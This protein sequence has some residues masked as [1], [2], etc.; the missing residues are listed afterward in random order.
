[1]KKKK[2]KNYEGKNRGVEEL[3][4]KKIGSINH[5]Y[6]YILLIITFFAF[7]I[8]QAADIKLVASVDRNPV[9]L[10]EQFSY[11]VEVSGSTQNLP[12]VNM[13]DFSDF[14]V[15]G[16]PSTSSSFQIINF[17]V[18]SSKNY[19][20]ILMPRKLG[21]FL[22]GSASVKYKGETIKSDPI[23]ITVVKGTGQAGQSQSG[24]TQT[25]SQDDIDVSD[26]AF[27]KVLPSK[28]TVYINEEVT[29]RYKLYFRTNISGNEIE[30]LPEAVGAWVEEYPIPQRPKVYTETV[31]GVQYSVAEIRKVAVFPSKAGKI[32]ISPMNM[33]LDIVMRRQRN[34]D[35]FSV[36]DDFFTDPFGQVVKKRVSSGSVELNVLPLPTANRPENFT[37][38]V[39]NFRLH[40]SIDKESVAA[41]NAISYKVK[42]SGLGLLKFLNELPI[43][44]P[45]DFEVYEPKISESINKKGA[46]INSNKEFDYVLI[47]RVPGDQKIKAKQL[48][49]FNPE[50]KKY[51]FL[52]I[53]EYKISV[54]P[55]KDIAM[56]VVSGAAL[57]KEEVQ[58]LGQD[59]RF[60]KEDLTNLQPIGYMPYQ[61]WWFYFSFI[62]PLG[63]LGIAWVYRGHMDKMSSNVQ[64]ARSRKARKLAHA[65]LK[66][67]RNYLKQNDPAGFYGAIS[68]SMIGYVADKSNRAAA[69]MLR[70]DVIKAL[71]DGQVDDHVQKKYIEC[72]D[73]ADFRRFA[74]GSANKE[75]MTS[76][77]KQVEKTLVDLEK[78]F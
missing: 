9:G 28:R 71:Q 59:I 47:P 54:T 74:P 19:T 72:L 41:N 42:I 65:H 37:G 62:F 22:L 29:L 36:F 77:Y 25:D 27:I 32:T 40:S 55:G 76:F 26:L 21:T 49:Y 8:S 50:T 45:P 24:T 51:H 30:K 39:G 31:K 35:P 20:M 23:K 66:K 12:N 52:N 78:Y 1:V 53:P 57:S 7:K 68:A 46:A 5:L 14:A 15:V 58:L 10:D 64:Y 33:I 17:K 60:I 44:F 38:L 2:I 61:N 43:T 56:G 67:A 6:Y 75:E 13:P 69:G 18:K 3:V 4:L 73:Q 63:L 70:E 11:E 48:S 16:G 34:R